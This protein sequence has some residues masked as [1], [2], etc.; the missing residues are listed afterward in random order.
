MHFFCAITPNP[1]AL[2]AAFFK[3]QRILHFL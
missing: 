2:I 1:S 3:A